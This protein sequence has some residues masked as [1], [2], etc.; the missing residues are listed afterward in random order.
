MVVLHLVGLQRRQHFRTLSQLPPR[1]LI[2]MLILGTC[3]YQFS[4]RGKEI[5]LERIGWRLPLLEFLNAMYIYSWTIKEYRY[6][7]DQPYRFLPLLTTPQ[8]WS[9]SFSPFL[10]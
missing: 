9:S 1:P 8:P 3:I 6:G 4:G 7:T 10:W 2:H 5:I